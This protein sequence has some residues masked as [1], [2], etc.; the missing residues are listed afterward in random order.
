MIDLQNFLKTPAGIITSLTTIIG[1]VAAVWKWG[2]GV[3]Q[4][5]WHRFTRY[6]PRVPRE[7]LR[8]VLKPRETWWYIG[9]MND[10]PVMQVVSHWYVTN[11][12][13]KPVEVLRAFLTKPRTEGLMVLVRHPKDNIYGRYQIQQGATTELSA[14]FWV[15]PPVQ[16][17]GK[18]FVATVVVLDQFGNEHRVKNVV[19]RGQ[20][21]PQQ[22]TDQPR[23]ES[24]HIIFDPVEKEVAAVLKAEL[25][26]YQQCGR[27]VGGLGS[28]Q[29]TYLNQTFRWS[30]QRLARSRLTQEP[31]DNP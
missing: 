18:D 27:R 26:R 17:V 8:L 22:K 19:F 30:R 9:S 3:L 15:Q 14:D 24:L 16:E 4:A 23:P 11:I 29:T 6:R 1:A 5:V 2:K 13:D 12:S 7:T 10:E 20:K 25:S 21:P 31:I 28:V